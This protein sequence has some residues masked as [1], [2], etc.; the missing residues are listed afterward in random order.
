MA[1]RKVSSDHV[2]PNPVFKLADGKVTMDAAELDRAAAEYFDQLHMSAAY[3]PQLFYACGWA[4][5]PSPFLGTQYPSPEYKSAY[6]QAVRLFWEHVK[7]KGWADRLSLYVSDEPHYYNHPNVVEWLGNIIGYTREVD[8]TIPVYSSTWGYVPQWQGILN[9][10]GIAQYGQFPMNTWQELRAAG[11]KAWFTT[12]GQMEIDTPY[13][14]CERLLPWY[15]YAHQVSG[16]E[17]WGFSWYTYD[18]FKFGWHSFIHQSSEPGEYSWVRYPNGD[19][20]MAYPGEVIGLD[21]PLSTIRLEQAREGIEDYEL[22]AALDQLAA[23]KPAA[24]AEIE[25]VLNEA[26]AL[27]PIPNAGGYRSTDILPDPDA[28]LAVRRKAGELLDRLQG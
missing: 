10:W 2:L 15:C 19:G 27:A 1:E 20:F 24:K 4:H 16:Y 25:A 12:D 17:F 3:F 8:P 21:G 5:P 9:H 14:A 23:A 18:P 22:L 26:R 13:N 11:D 6:Q 7:A 28:L